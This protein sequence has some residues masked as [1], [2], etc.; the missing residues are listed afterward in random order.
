MRDYTTCVANPD[1]RI[2]MQFNRTQVH[3]VVSGL[4]AITLSS[5]MVGVVGEEADG[6]DDSPVAD[7]PLAGQSSGNPPSPGWWKDSAG[8]SYYFNG[9]AYCRAGSGPVGQISGVIDPV[10]PVDRMSPCGGA[11]G[12]PTVGWWTDSKGLGYYYNGST[13]CREAF[14]GQGR[15][16]LG[17]SEPGTPVAAMGA[18]GTTWHL[19][20]DC[21]PGTC[22]PRN[23]LTP[24][25]SDPNAN[26]TGISCSPANAVCNTPSGARAF[27]CR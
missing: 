10:T 23:C 18:C 12:P 6:R 17:T 15:P 21:R 19:F 26:S 16:I 20:Q 2:H 11:K 3:I 22:T 8:R 5:C 27:V 4:L 14:L 7:S 1:T 24:A 9:S 25:I 13:Y